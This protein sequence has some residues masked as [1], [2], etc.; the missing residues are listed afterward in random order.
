MTSIKAFVYDENRYCHFVRSLYG[1]AETKQKISQTNNEHS[2]WW[3]VNRM[4][5]KTILKTT[6]KSQ[7][8]C[9]EYI[10]AEATQYNLLRVGSRERCDFIAH[11]EALNHHRSIAAIR[12]QNTTV[13]KQP[14]AL[15]YRLFWLA[16]ICI[17]IVLYWVYLYGCISVVRCRLYRCAALV[18]LC[19]SE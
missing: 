11:T 9:I 3:A 13:C 8:H 16:C 2:R 15:L 14:C 1:Y 19:K 12:D 18:G 10:N 17:C 5:K 6:S 7:S 4:S